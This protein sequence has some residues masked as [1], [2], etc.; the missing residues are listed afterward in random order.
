MRRG[1]SRR[2][3]PSAGAAQFVFGTEFEIDTCEPPQTL[4]DLIALDQRRAELRSFL[5]EAPE[6]IL[7]RLKEVIEQHPPV[8][9]GLISLGEQ[10]GWHELAQPLVLVGR[11]KMGDTGECLH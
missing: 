7:W 11:R 1:I 3:V 8:K 9:Q 6:V 4:T 5:S 2:R 10:T